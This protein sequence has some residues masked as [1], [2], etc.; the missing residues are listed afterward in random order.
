MTTLFSKDL[1][2]R[3]SLSNALPSFGQKKH[4]KKEESKPCY[5]FLAPAY[6]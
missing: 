2:R 6:Y 5:L 3:L 1:E 4:S